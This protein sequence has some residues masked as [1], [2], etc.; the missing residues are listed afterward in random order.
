MLA[1]KDCAA[2]GC[3]IRGYKSENRLKF[4]RGGRYVG[5]MEPDAAVRDLFMT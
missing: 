2:F 4:V 5:E 1:A 3:E